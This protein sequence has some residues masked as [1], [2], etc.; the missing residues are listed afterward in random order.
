M[1]SQDYHLINV[2]LHSVV[3]LLTLFVYNILMG[4]DKWNISFYAAA[5]FA[6]HPIHTEAV[7]RMYI[8]FVF[9]YVHILQCCS[10]CFL[11]IRYL[12]L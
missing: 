7:I 3:C 6:V 10:L 5:L 4:P 12:E 9:V 8:Y 11:Y 2:M 1:V